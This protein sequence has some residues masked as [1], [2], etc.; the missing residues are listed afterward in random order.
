MKINLKNG[1]DK[2]IFGMKQKDVSAVYGTPDRNYKDEDD[3][4]IFTYNK[5]KMR[6]TFYKDEDFKMGYIVASSPDL[7]LF[8]N[9]VIGKNIKDVKNEL[10]KK[11]ITKFTQEEFDTFENYFNEDNWLLFQT[12][13]EEV[14]KLEVGAIINDK[15][16]FEWKFG[17]K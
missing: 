13:F 16:E 9:K 1:I 10:A 15:D 14:V 5:F 8:C 11:S 17:K 3:N 4:V 6:L 2:L 12:E 7:E